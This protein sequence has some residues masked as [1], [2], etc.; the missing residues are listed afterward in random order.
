MML[1]RAKV[2]CDWIPA[3]SADD[4]RTENR[5]RLITTLL[6]PIEFYAEDR[7]LDTRLMAEKPA[8]TSPPPSSTPTLH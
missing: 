4:I 8:G 3:P 1:K 7:E 6:A 5:G 2:A